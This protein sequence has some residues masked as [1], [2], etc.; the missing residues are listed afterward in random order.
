MQTIPPPSYPLAP[1][2]QATATSRAA[3]ES[4]GTRR[5]TL[6]VLAVD[7]LATGAATADEVAHALSQHPKAVQP[8]IS[9]LRALGLVEPSGRYGLSSLGHKAIRWRLAAGPLRD[10]LPTELKEAVLHARQASEIG[11][12][13]ELNLSN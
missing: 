4:S 11:S 3:A 5:R 9:E 1:G 13:P 12:T 10:D 8:R 2:Y 6:Q 7:C